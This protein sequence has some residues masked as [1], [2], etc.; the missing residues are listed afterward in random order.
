MYPGLSVSV[1]WFL[2]FKALVEDWHVK[3]VFII[4]IIIIIIII[5]YLYHTM[6]FKRNVH[7]LY[8]IP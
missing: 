5:S 7:V 4:I 2:L 3:R 6:L 8:L 1:T